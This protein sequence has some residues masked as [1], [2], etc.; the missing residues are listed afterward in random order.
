[1]EHRDIRFASASFISYLIA[2]ATKTKKKVESDDSHAVSVLGFIVFAGI[3]W[4]LSSN[5]SW[6]PLSF[7]EVN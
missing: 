4:L 5:R 3:A 7:T 2:L 1:M 6:F